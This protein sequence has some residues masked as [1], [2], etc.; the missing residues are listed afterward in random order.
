MHRALPQH[1]SGFGPLAFFDFGHRIAG[2]C[3]APFPPIVIG[4][5]SPMPTVPQLVAQAEPHG[6][7]RNTKTWGL[8][9]P[10]NKIGRKGPCVLRSWAKKTCEEVSWRP[11]RLIRIILVPEALVSRSPQI[12]SPWASL[13]GTPP[14]PRVRCFSVWVY[15]HWDGVGMVQKR[16][17]CPGCYTGTS[18]AF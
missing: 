11:P 13:C 5:V 6:V 2:W 4:E 14:E 12:C 15:P 16:W 3:W 18:F 1:T 9:P 17:L 8:E 7:Y 10:P